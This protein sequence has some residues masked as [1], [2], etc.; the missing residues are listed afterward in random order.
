VHCYS[1]LKLDNGEEKS[2]YLEDNFFAPNGHGDYAREAWALW[3]G[4]PLTLTNF[5]KH[6]LMLHTQ[7]YWYLSTEHGRIKIP[8][9]TKVCGGGEKEK[10]KKGRKKNWGGGGQRNLQIYLLLILS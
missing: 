4:T 9:K 5:C 1:S 8:Q 3:G 7:T 10:E 6:A 2:Y